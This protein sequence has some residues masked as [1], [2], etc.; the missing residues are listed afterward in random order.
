VTETASAPPRVVSTPK[1]VHDALQEAYLR[2]YDTAFW[3]RDP[4]LLAERRALLSQPGVL[5][6]RPLLEP[7]MPYESTLSI[8]EVCGQCGI[9]AS[10]SA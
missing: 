8:G 5:F 9:E 10:C 2:Y 3:L 1:G 7:V 4:G 6:T